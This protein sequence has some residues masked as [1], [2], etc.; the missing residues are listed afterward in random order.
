L[1]NYV[2]L[3][4]AAPSGQLKNAA[5]MA[6]PFFYEYAGLASRSSAA[7]FAEYAAPTPCHKKSISPSE[8]LY[9]ARHA[10]FYCL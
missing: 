7:K 10:F 9:N 3:Q 1:Q 5:L 6:K 4:I 2:F 8:M